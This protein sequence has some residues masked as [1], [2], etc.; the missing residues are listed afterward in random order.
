MN[1]E[2]MVSLKPADLDLVFSKQDKSGFSRTGVNS[3][4][5]QI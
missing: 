2:Q 5:L 4:T 3:L 1:L